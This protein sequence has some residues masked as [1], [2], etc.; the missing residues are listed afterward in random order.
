MPGTVTLAVVAFFATLI[1]EADLTLWKT[2]LVI[3]K[4]KSF[5][6]GNVC[7]NSVSDRRDG[8]GYPLVQ[9]ECDTCLMM[10]LRIR[11]DDAAFCS[12]LS[13]S[14]R[15]VVAVFP[16]LVGLAIP[17]DADVATSVPIV[18][19]VTLQL[20]VCKGLRMSNPRVRAI[21]VKHPF[22]EGP[23]P[24]GGTPSREFPFRDLVG[25][26]EILFRKRVRHVISLVVQSITNQALAE[27]QQ[28]AFDGCALFN[29]YRFLYADV[30]LSLR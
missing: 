24:S 26:Q 14:Y 11:K 29:L 10:P 21:A 5:L 4:S 1:G 6:R 30:G 9:W 13:V 22:V 18:Q 17:P 3:D 12:A 27:P 19:K 7:L 15:K 16:R 8:Q 2:V 23:H 20:Y 28:T 25:L